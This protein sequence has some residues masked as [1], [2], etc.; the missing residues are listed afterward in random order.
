MACRQTGRMISGTLK[1]KSLSAGS[2]RGEMLGMLAIK[3]FLLVVEEYHGVITLDNRICCNNKDAM[4]TFE[5]KSKQVP[6]SKANTD[7]QRVLRTINAR[8]KS[9]FVQRQVKAHQDEVKK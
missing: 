7:I 8:T 2:Y 5:K 6:A 9:N 1:E 4:F 3:L